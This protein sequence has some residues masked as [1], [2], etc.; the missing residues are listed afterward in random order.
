MAFEVGCQENLKA[1]PKQN[2]QVPM[3]RGT[4][5]SSPCRTR[6]GFRDRVGEIGLTEVLIAP[7]SPWQNA[8]A[9]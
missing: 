3:A 1:E 9:E 7:Q 5:P 6:N 2:S 4:F 8:F